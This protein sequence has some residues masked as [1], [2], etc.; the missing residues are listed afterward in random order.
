MRADWNAANCHWPL[1]SRKICRFLTGPVGLP[2]P[3]AACALLRAGLPGPPRT[4]DTQSF[5]SESSAFW[6]R[7]A[8]LFSAFASVSNHS[9]TSLKPSS[10][11]LR[12]IPG[13]ISVYS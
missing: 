12:A 13:Y 2:R 9:A 3:V 5:G 4:F 1:F 6:K 11:A 7:P 10:R 8:W